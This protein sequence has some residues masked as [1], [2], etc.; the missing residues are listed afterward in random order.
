METS[1]LQELWFYMEHN[2][3]RFQGEGDEKNWDEA[4]KNKAKKV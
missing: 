2:C 1:S 4:H 3:F